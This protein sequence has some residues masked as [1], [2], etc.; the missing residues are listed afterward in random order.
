MWID[1]LLYWAWV[2]DRKRGPGG[3][4]LTEL[5]PVP[6]TKRIDYVTINKGV[7]GLEHKL[8]IGVWDNN[9]YRPLHRKELEFYTR[10][11]GKSST[12][13]KEL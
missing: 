3:I 11:Y 4:F 8:A 5:P 6:S 9:V 1:K 2:E 10:Q 12:E 7:A 13:N